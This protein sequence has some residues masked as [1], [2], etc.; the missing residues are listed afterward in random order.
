[1]VQSLDDFEV[2]WFSRLFLCTTS[3]RSYG[4]DEVLHG[5]E[6]T[7]QILLPISLLIS[8]N[9]IRGLTFWCWRG[10]ARDVSSLIIVVMNGEPFWWVLSIRHPFRP[11]RS[12]SD[13][14]IDC[15]RTFLRRLWLQRW[16]VSY[17]LSICLQAASDT[18]AG[19]SQ[20]YSLTIGCWVLSMANYSL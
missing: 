13:K 5:L 7:I 10:Q 9:R 4:D 20:K 14:N 18:P 6:D 19:R 17:D 16:K 3:P 11:I 1:M 2:H 8:T 12:I 15:C